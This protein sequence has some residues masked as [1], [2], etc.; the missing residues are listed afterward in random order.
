MRNRMLEP[1]ASELDRDEEI[2]WS[3][4]PKRGLVLRRSDWGAIPFSLLWGGL[5]FSFTIAA[6]RRADPLVILVGL[7]FS[8]LGIYIIIGRFVVDAVQRSTTY[9]AVTDRRAIILSTFLGWRVKSIDL[10]TLTDLSLTERRDGRG[11]IWLGRSQGRGDGWLDPGR[12]MPGAHPP[13]ALELVDRGRDVYN[14]IRQAQTAA[15]KSV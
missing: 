8:A 7:V 5:S 14:L 1:I 11:T 15:L 4:Q 3:G 13:S 10:R 9:Y 6:F 2:R 12:S